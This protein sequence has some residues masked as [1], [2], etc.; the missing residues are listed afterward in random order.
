MP[1]NEGSFYIDW[2][3]GIKRVM[4]NTGL[5]TKLLARFKTDITLGELFA[6]LEAGDYEKARMAVH[7]V[8][9]VAANLSLIALYRQALDLETQIKGKS[10]APGA[11]ETLRT[12]FTE[13]LANIDRVVAEHA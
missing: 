13:T 7:T 9:G 6:A 4:G 3:D 10:V 12:C 2:D 5:Y 11:F 1:E 8:K